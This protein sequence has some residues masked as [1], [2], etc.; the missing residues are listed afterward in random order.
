MNKY[1]YAIKVGT[2]R[3]IGGVISATSMDD[4]V[5]RIVALN[6]LTIRRY[7][8]TVRPADGKKIESADWLLDGKKAFVQVSAPAERYV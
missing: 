4:A 2:R 3:R 7:E 8:P 5:E 6:G 1:A